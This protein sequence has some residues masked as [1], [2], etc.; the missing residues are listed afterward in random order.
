MTHALCGRSRRL[1]KSL[2]TLL[3]ALLAASDNNN[4]MHDSVVEI[5]TQVQYY[6][7]ASRLTISLLR[8]VE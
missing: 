6:S 7:M 4:A 5:L 2:I 1:W 8:T 3:N